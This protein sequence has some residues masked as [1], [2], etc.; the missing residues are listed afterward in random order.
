M[1]ICGTFPSEG[2]ISEDEF[3]NAQTSTT[4]ACLFNSCFHLVWAD[5][6]IPFFVTITERPPRTLR[7]EEVE[8]MLRAI[9]LTRADATLRS[10]CCWLRMA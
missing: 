6:P 4:S 2:S 1:F 3:C 8:R 7:W 10:C 9:C 5:S